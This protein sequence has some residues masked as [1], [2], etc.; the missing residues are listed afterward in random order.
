MSET[1]LITKSRLVS[2]LRQ[3]GIEAGQAVMLHA[4]VKA[5]GWVVGGPDVVLEAIFDILTPDG[6]LLM[7]ISWEDSTYE[8]PDWPP[9]KQQV[10]L[11]E[12]PP[13]DPARSRAYRGWGILTEY[14]RTWPGSYRSA[15]PDESFA[16]VGRLAEWLTANHSLQYGLGPDC[17]V[18]KLCEAGG[19][20]LVLGSPM[21][22]VTLIHYSEHMAKV[23]HKPVYRYSVPVIEDGSR[24]WVD[25]EEYD[26]NKP[27][28]D[29]TGED[30][31]KIITREALQARIGRQGK[32]GAADSYFYDAQRLHEFAVAWLEQNLSERAT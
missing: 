3:L 24:K 12:C 13:F 32:V 25:I 20:V 30:Y 16:A 11:Q 9:D 21:H 8:I 23:P 1:P 18:A 17:P 31:F 6:T 7:L 5:I 10:Y 4:S 26:T 2:D 14:L 28:G 19:K 22:D 27:I 29:W 15:N